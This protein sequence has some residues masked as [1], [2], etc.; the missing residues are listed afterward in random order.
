MAI[1]RGGVS[2]GE[3]GQDFQHCG[4]VPGPIVGDA[5]LR[6]DAADANVELVGAGLL[7]RLGVAVS[8][9]PVFG[10]FDNAAQLRCSS[11]GEGSVRG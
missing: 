1:A 9:L 11:C 3:C 5:L 2:A 6:V 8:H 7:D 10:E 4:V